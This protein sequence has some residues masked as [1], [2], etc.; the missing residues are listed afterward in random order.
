MRE[1]SCQPTRLKKPDPVKPRV[2]R[3]KALTLRASHYARVSTSPC[4]FINPK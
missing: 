2:L 3:V 4:D 1:K